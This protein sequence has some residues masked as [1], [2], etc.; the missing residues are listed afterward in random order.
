MTGTKIRRLVSSNNAVDMKGGPTVYGPTSMPTHHGRIN[1]VHRNQGR[2][3]HHQ[4]PQVI[5]LKTEPFLGSQNT[6]DASIPYRQT[7]V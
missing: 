2:G 6:E 7:S 5:G 3:F 4:K 1:L